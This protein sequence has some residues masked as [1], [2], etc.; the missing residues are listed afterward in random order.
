MEQ[1]VHLVLFQPV[2]ILRTLFQQV[3]LG[4]LSTWLSWPDVSMIWLRLYNKQGVGVNKGK[5]GITRKMNTY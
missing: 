1:W 3:T 4:I 5:E 2:H